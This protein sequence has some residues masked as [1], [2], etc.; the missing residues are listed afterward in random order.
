[1]SEILNENTETSLDVVQRCELFQS[2]GQQFGSANFIGLLVNCFGKEMT[3]NAIDNLGAAGPMSGS[4]L[5]EIYGN[6]RD[7]EFK[8]EIR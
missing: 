7:F 8:G 3:A 2:I 5:I 6:N 1:M 4:Q